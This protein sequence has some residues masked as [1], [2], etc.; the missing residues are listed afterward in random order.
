MGP[1]L[2]S[3]IPFLLSPLSLPRS[4]RV[5][6][7]QFVGQRMSKAS[8]RPA[9]TAAESGGRKKR[10]Y[11]YIGNLGAMSELVFFARGVGSEFICV[12]LTQ[13]QF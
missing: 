7:V 11:I 8:G 9:Q 5:A 4:E 12:N 6:R 3:P 1:S 2:L 10:A 13:L